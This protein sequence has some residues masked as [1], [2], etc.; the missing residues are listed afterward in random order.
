M[1]VSGYHIYHLRIGSAINIPT[2]SGFF[3]LNQPTSDKAKFVSRLL[4]ASNSCISICQHYNC[5]N[6]IM[7]W[8]LYMNLL[9]LCNVRGDSGNIEAYLWSSN[10]PATF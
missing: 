5:V 7:L 4:A 3:L 8:L 9:L 10:C 2:T 6:D 1:G